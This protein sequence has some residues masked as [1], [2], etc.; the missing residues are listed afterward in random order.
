[1]RPLLD[2]P[3]ISARYFFPSRAKLPGACWVESQGLRLACW[4]SAPPSDKPVLVHFHGNGELVHHWIDDLGPRVQDMGW[5]LFLAEYRGYGASEGK[6]ALQ[7]MLDDVP[8][9]L[10]AVGLPPERMVV[11]GRSIGSI[12]AIEAVHRVPELAGL[13][14]ESGVADLYERL[15]LRMR[16]VEL[17]CTD[18]E[19]RAAVKERFDHGAK[20]AA[21]SGPSL[22]MHAE[23][24]H[25]VGI[26]HGVANAEAA[27]D[28]TLVRF[29][30]GDHNNILFANQSAYFRVLRDFLALR[31]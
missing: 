9:I 27:Q 21:W 28:C 15:A 5:E 23:H 31:V 18:A 30:R 3:I 14:L 2:H 6:P 7:A 24:D 26:H 22:V 11:F 1:V 17:G 4:R 20:L 13:V 8:A 16:P 10:D 19:L 12:Y 25:L 29:P